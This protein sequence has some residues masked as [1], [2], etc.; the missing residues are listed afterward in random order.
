MCRK[1][2][3]GIE[4]GVGRLLR[5]ESGGCLCAARAVSGMKVARA[6]LG[7]LDGTCEPVA[8]AWPSAGVS[9]RRRER[10]P[11]AAGTVRG[12]VSMSGTG[13]GRL[14]VAM[15]PGN[16]GGV[17]G[18]GHPGPFGGQPVWPGGAR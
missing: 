15:N 14:V 5:E 12:R 3:E 17:K 18:A 9:G 8:L 13:A 1:E 4:T 16:A 7:L 6:W 10:E 2:L 11:Q